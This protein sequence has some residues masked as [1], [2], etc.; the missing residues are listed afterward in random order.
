MSASSQSAETARKNFMDVALEEMRKFELK[1]RELRRESK[2]ERAHLLRLPILA[3]G[4]N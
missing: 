3:E 1:E 4:I 2:Q